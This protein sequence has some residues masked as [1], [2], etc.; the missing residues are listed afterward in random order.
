M[1]Y[2]KTGAL[3]VLGVFKAVSSPHLEFCA[4]NY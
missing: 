3:V 1:K 2:D 4:R